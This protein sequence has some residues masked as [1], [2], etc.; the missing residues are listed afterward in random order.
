[1]GKYFVRRDEC[2]RHTLFPGVEA[3]TAA[4]EKLMLSWVELEPGSVV[5]RHSHPHE[6]LGMLIEG[7][8]EFEIGGETQML[9]VGDMWR[10]PGGVLHRVVAGDRGAKALDV[11]H[12]VREDY[13]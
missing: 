10:I 12:P 9:K 8:V 11:F 13:L 3:F 2:G 5:E 6:Q 7:T 4:G 1:M